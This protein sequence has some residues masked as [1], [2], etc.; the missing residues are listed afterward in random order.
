MFC[1]GNFTSP[2]AVAYKICHVLAAVLSGVGVSAAG[3]EA[4]QAD[5]GQLDPADLGHLGAA[6]V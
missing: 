5:H 1:S 4:V 6:C 3:V 2:E